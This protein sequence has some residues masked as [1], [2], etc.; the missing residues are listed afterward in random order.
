M[1]EKAVLPS[2][3]TVI[4]KLNI[5]VPTIDR[6]EPRKIVSSN[7]RGNDNIIHICITI[8]ISTIFDTATGQCYRLNELY[9]TVIYTGCM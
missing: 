9:F 7:N 2:R 1:A 6:S 3:V 5:Q 8:L 4:A